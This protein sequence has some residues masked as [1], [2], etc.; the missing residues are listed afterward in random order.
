MEI[1]I[2]KNICKKLLKEIRIYPYLS[3]FIRG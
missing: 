2:T 3:A 1:L